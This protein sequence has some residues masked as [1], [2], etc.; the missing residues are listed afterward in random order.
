ME[1]IAEIWERRE[2]VQKY[3]LDSIQ[4][5][6]LKILPALS[7][8]EAEAESNNYNDWEHNEK[9]KKFTGY[10]QNARRK[11]IDGDIANGTT[12]A[13]PIKHIIEK[14]GRGKN[15]VNRAMYMEDKYNN[16]PTLESLGLIEYY[17]TDIGS[18][19]PQRM[20]YRKPKC[21]NSSKSIVPLFQNAFGTN[22]EGLN[23]K[24][25]LTS[26]LYCS[27]ILINM[28]I[29]GV[30]LY[31]CTNYVQSINT[32]DEMCEFITGFINEYGDELQELDYEHI[33][34]Q[35]LDYHNKFLG[36]VYTINSKGEFLEQCSIIDENA[37]NENQ[38][39]LICSKFD[40]EQTI[41]AKTEIGTIS[42]K[43]SKSKR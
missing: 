15:T 25:I 8:E 14:T 32:Y 35:E 30:I 7:E 33:S 38:D 2:E 4:E 19:Y 34:L 31:Y 9:A 28:Y 40:L 29:G 41:N 11:Q 6:I 23:Q 12:K 13:L 5:E 42:E 39:K 26:L 18:R 24:K 1:E 27:N 22:D 17:G 43:V 10:H 20:Y 36:G 21:S 3:K 16:K 37:P